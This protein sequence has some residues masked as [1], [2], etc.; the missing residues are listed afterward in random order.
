MDYRLI[1]GE[2]K[3]GGR[4]ASG[5]KRSGGGAAGNKSVSG[6]AT[7]STG[8]DRIE[9]QISVTERNIAEIKGKL[10]DLNNKI[11]SLVKAKNYNQIKLN[12]RKGEELVK[13]KRA[14]EKELK[15]LYREGKAL[16]RD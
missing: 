9:K 15:A 14:M 3:M 2:N 4:G 10:D 6:S 5:K 11:P 13:K 12:N 16:S 1:K 8:I 7:P